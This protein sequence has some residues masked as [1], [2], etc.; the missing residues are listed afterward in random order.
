[1]AVITQK[2]KRLREYFKSWFGELT[3][4]VKGE[5]QQEIQE[6]EKVLFHPED[7]NGILLGDISEN[8]K[9]LQQRIMDS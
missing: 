1:M 6:L 3:D 8:F 5:F 7:R 4:D 9:R 2:E